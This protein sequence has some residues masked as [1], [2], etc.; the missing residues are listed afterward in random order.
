MRCLE[1][2][3][4]QCLCYALLVRDSPAWSYISFVFTLHLEQEC[5]TIP[6]LWLACARFNIL[7]HSYVQTIH[8]HNVVQ[9]LVAIYQASPARFILS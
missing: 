5:S 4:C 3:V 1:L 6:N 9:G 7:H 8:Q 2:G